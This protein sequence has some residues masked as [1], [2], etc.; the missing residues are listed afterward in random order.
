MALVSPEQGL[1]AHFAGTVM[2][3]YAAVGYP[4]APPSEYHHFPGAFTEDWLDR[5]PSPTDTSGIVT[6]ADHGKA[7]R[8]TPDL[9]GDA[10]ALK[11]RTQIH[12]E[13]HE[14]WL[15]IASHN[16]AHWLGHKVIIKAF[17]SVPEDKTFGR[18]RDA[19]P[20][21]VVQAKGEKAWYLGEAARDT[22]AD[23]T[24]MMRRGDMMIVPA[25]YWHDVRTLSGR[26]VHF[27]IGMCLDRP[28]N[29]AD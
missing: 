2:A 22:Q 15:R 29:R 5:I 13:F 18:H 21:V 12:S 28:L 25:D 26:S 24:V 16:L 9:V 20:V 14:P 10:Y 19:L 23:P 1:G 27:S 4:Q 17:E 8:L 3:A 7:T 11:P 6:L